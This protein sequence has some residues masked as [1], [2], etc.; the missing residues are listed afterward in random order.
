MSEPEP[1][2][3][4]ER[5]L[6]CI[7]E[8]INV[9]FRRQLNKTMSTTVR[10]CLLAIESSQP[11][12]PEIDIESYTFEMLQ[13]IFELFVA[14]LRESYSIFLQLIQGEELQRKQ[15]IAIMYSHVFIKNTIGFLLQLLIVVSKAI[16]AT[17]KNSRYL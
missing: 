16:S 1:E 10:K 17:E 12:Y 11:S 5:L 8:V 3:E 15:V 13:C 6:V 7:D 9:Q 2:P 14:L 4:R